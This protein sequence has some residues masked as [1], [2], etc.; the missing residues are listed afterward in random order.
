MA[1]PT[2]DPTDDLPTRLRKHADHFESMI[3]NLEEYL[4]K[5]AH[6]LADK[7]AAEVRSDIQM[8]KNLIAKWRQ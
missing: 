8:L 1:D 2:A 5:E 4:S 3:R 7:A 6:N